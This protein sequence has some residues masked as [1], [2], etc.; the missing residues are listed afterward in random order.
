MAMIVDEFGGIAGL[1]TL[2]QLVSVIVGNVREEDQP[3]LLQ[4]APVDE[5]TFILDASLTVNEAYQLLSI[6]IPMGDYQTIAGFV[7]SK[8]GKIPIVGD[9]FEHDGVEF[10]VTEMQGVKIKS[11]TIE[12]DNASPAHNMPKD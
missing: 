6:N 8:L 9:H 1:V 11:I 3:E 10:T 2:K 12:K 4:Y 7:L 5:N